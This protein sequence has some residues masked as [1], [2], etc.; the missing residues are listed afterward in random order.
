M[1][2]SHQTQNYK[3]NQQTKSLVCIAWSTWSCPICVLVTAMRWSRDVVQLVVRTNPSNDQELLR[4]P[5]E[6]EKKCHNELIGLG[7]EQLRIRGYGRPVIRS[8]LIRAMIKPSLPVCLHVRVVILPPWMTPQF[9]SNSPSLL[10]NETKNITAVI[11]CCAICNC[12]KPACSV[13][14]LNHN[15]Q[16]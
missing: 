15:C 16:Y 2:V 4:F 13:I 6:G 12:C 3:R 1:P 14:F 11:L 9:Y 5:T 8:T 10:C 7:A